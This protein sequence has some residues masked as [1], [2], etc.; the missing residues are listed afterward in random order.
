MDG[1]VGMNYELIWN[2]PR[3]MRSAHRRPMSTTVAAVPT[4]PTFPSRRLS[5]QQ[6]SG[7]F[8]Y[9]DDRASEVMRPSPNRVQLQD[10]AAS[11]HPAD[12]V[13]RSS[14]TSNSGSLRPS[15]IAARQHQFNFSDP[16][17]PNFSH[18]RR[19]SS[20][21]DQTTPPITRSVFKFTPQAKSYNSS[22]L[23]KSFDF[24]KQGNQ[25]GTQGVE[26]TDSTSSTNAPSTVWDEL[27][28]L[29]SRLH[30]LELTGKL[31][32]TSG[33]AVSKASD[34]RPPTATTTMTTMS[35][36]PKRSNAQITETGSTTSSQREATQR[37]AY[38]ILVSALAK[39]RAFLNPEVYRALESAA[40]DAMVLSS[41]LGVPGQPGPI[42]SGA[43]AIGSGTNVTDRQLRR[44]AD[45]VC[46]SLTELCVAL[47]EDVSQNR[48]APVE[49]VRSQQTYH[50]D[51]PKTPTV[52]KTYNGLTSGRRPSVQVDTHQ[53]QPVQRVIT[54]PT[55]RP[56]SK[57]EERRQTLL[58][59]FT[60]PR[61]SGNLNATSPQQDSSANRRSSLLI[62]RTRRAGTE[63]PEDTREQGTKSS[64]FRTRARTEEPEDTSGRK[65]S[66]LR[67]R[68]G[69]TGEG[70]DETSRF[71]APLRAYTEVASSRGPGREYTEIATSRGPARDYTSRTQGRIYGQTREQREQR[72]QSE[73]REVQT[74]TTESRLPQASALPR[75]RFGSSN[76][77]G[78]SLSGAPSA[79]PTS[80]RKY[81]DR[82]STSNDRDRHGVTSPVDRYPEDRNRRPMSL[83]GNLTLNRS[84]SLSSRRQERENNVTMASTTAN[85][86]NY[87]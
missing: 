33:A 14:R 38:P 27:D 21:N 56:F 22:P 78:V 9:E 5:E 16:D 32:A 84:G 51:A 85:G 57:F 30:R 7:R 68:R 62:T 18:S 36:S 34:E 11:V 70:E 1:F 37:E 55:S 61:N 10:K 6:D 82:S 86:G 69:T 73:K 39:T 77:G 66:I 45:G 24:G 79:L 8:A 40:N 42:S 46:R 74:H 49:P 50:T 87:R 47:G 44:K 28:E 81:F 4:S 12:D 15:P 3:F 58:N 53:A 17:S 25:D 19:H 76:V 13:H 43:S 35:S 83:G 23:V 26:G 41:L 48:S 65:T 52:A 63:E 64:L 71:G 59:G 20:V 2:Q 29:K 60:S 31:P 54:S 72:D 80:T 75:R 67:S